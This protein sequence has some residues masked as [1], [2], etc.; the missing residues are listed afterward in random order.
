MLL[1]TEYFIFTIISNII[2]NILVSNCEGYILSVFILCYDDLINKQYSNY[3][4]KYH[5]LQFDI[6]KTTLTR[7]I[8]NIA[9]I[10]E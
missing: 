3:S 7:L 4:F 9:T 5:K 6:I 10:I 2:T 1:N 8:K